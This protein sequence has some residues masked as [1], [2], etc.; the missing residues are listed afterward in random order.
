MATEHESESEAGIDEGYA[1]KATH[2]DTNVS[3]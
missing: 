2:S 3:L 1:S